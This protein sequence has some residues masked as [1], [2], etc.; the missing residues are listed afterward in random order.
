LRAQR[1]RQASSRA[2]EQ[3]S[4]RTPGAQDILKRD[5]QPSAPAAKRAG[6]ARPSRGE[7]ALGTKPIQ[8]VSPLR[9]RCSTED[10]L[11]SL[12]KQSR[13][14]LGP[15]QPAQGA[16]QS[17]SHPVLPPNARHGRR[18]SWMSRER[19]VRPALPNAAKPPAERY[20]CA[21]W[22]HCMKRTL[23]ALST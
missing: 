14:D 17:E 3:A 12:I 22:P 13:C 1:E 4:Q 21:G 23:H 10:P 16:N 6:G 18:G 20:P 7:I 8:P 9:R 11:L 19:C 5:R 15:A 2:V